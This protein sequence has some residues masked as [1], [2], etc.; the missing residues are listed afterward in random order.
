MDI[1]QRGGMLPSTWEGL[2]HGNHDDGW[3][4]SRHDD[5]ESLIRPGRDV[6]RARGERGGERLDVDMGSGRRLGD[7]GSI[8]E[9][10]AWRERKRGDVMDVRERDHLSDRGR[11][12]SQS[13]IKHQCDAGK[14]EPERGYFVRWSRCESL[15]NSQLSAGDSRS[16]VYMARWTDEPECGGS[17]MDEFHNTKRKRFEWHLPGHDDCKLHKHVEVDE[18]HKDAVKRFRHV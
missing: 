9:G 2:E 11:D 18:S 4:A 17:I 13:C 16:R 3:G 8:G 5:D 1:R 10:A 12:A 6:E 7:M 14:L 15:S